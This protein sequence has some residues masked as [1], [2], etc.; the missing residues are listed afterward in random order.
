MT[1]ATSDL[2]LPGYWV[3]AG[4][5]AFSREGGAGPTG[6]WCTLP[7]PS[8]PDEK[9]AL[10][11]SSIGPGIIAWS[12]GRTDEPGLIHY[13]TGQSWRWT[14]GQKRF[15]ILWY[16]LGDDGRFSYRSGVKR[17]AKGTGKDPMAAAMCDCE[18]LGP[19]EPYDRDDRT[20]LWLARARGVPLVQVMSNSEDQSKKVLR[21]A[22]A[23]W[24]IDAREHYGLD[25]GE[26]RTIIKGTGARFEIPTSAEA[27]SEGDPITFGVLN[28]SHHMTDSNGG[29]DNAAV[30]RRNVAKSPA[31]IQARAVEFTNAHRQASGSVAE[32]SF[33]AWQAQQAPTYRGKQDILYDSIEAP[34]LTDILTHEGRMAGLTAAYM[35]AP[36]N[37]KIRISDEMVDRRTT[38]ADSI[39][40]YLNGLGAEEDAWVDPGFFDALA[41]PKVVADRDVIA[42]FVDC[43]KS[44]DATGATATRLSD[45]Y[46]FTVGVWSRPRGWSER[47]RG[48]W[49]APRAE[50]DATVRS[51]WGRYDVVWM[52]VDPS[53]AK[54]DEDDALYWQEVV[55]GW[56][57][58][59]GPKLKVWATPGA[60]GDPV[61]FDMRLSQPG[62][63]NRNRLFTQCAEWLSKV[64]DGDDGQ[65]PEKVSPFRHDGDSRLRTHAHNARRRPNPWGVSLGKVTR[66][67]DKLVDLAVCMVGSVMGAR[68]ALNSGKVKQGRQR[69]GRAV[70][71]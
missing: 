30:I 19:V 66:D 56:R 4:L 23:M 15:L 63:V 38:V 32:E 52:G 16:A 7:W 27:S 59:F 28:E 3:D 70:F 33:L 51:I 58:D 14:E 21:I 44:H 24:S 64:I 31:S 6:A 50:V 37:D 13:M 61:R 25:P 17:G 8:D 55:D 46:T 26:T 36:W 1:T 45:L 42:L 10:V 43:S 2:L 48:K 40:Y 41:E 22:N 62:G 47:Q 34:P 68:E 12:E 65:G 69:T 71:R 35:D 54:D 20:G 18:L 11:R 29:I 53:P 9:M 67:S 49:R 60:H 57:R 39:R 5:R